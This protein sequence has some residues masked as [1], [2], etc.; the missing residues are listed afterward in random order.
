MSRASAAASSTLSRRMRSRS[1]HS[2]PSSKRSARGACRRSTEVCGYARRAGL[3]VIADGKRG[4]IGSTARAY[5]EA[6]LE[7][8]PAARRRA[9]RQSVARARRGR[10]VPRRPFAAAAPASSCS[11]TPRMPAATCRTSCSGRTSDVAPRRRPGRRM[12]RGFDGEVGLSSVGAV[13]GATHP[14]AVAEARRLMPRTILLL[15]GVGAQGGAVADLGRAFQSGPASALVAASRSVIYAFREIGRATSG[16]RRAPRRRGSSARSGPPPAGSAHDDWRRYVAPGRVSAR[17]DDR[18]RP[19][20]RRHERRRHSRAGRRRTTT[21]ADTHDRRRRRRFYTVRA[22]DTFAVIARKTGVPVATIA[23]LNPKV[24][25]DLAPH[26]RED[27]HP[28]EAAPRS[29]VAL[30]ARPP[31][32]ASLPPLRRRCTRAPGSSRTR[33]PARCSL[34]RTP[35]EPPDRLD[36]EADDR[37]RRAR[38]PL[39]QRRRRR[40]P[41]RGRGRRVERRPRP[42]RASSPCATWSRRR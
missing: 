30:L 19:D 9:H 11:S 34:A 29:L 36:H 21:T 42:G 40:R 25:V 35:H 3:L 39:A 13:V 16:R 12:G 8:D 4:D 32:A 1:S 7:G 26:R 20:P 10:A 23:R 28:S 41:A 5:A 33:A 2:S 38:A 24:D 14:R 18:R 22:G 17:R 15:P 27:P 37:A 6:Y 31:V